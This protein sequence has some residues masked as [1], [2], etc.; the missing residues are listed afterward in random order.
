MVYV[1]DRLHKACCERDT[2]PVRLSPFK[3]SEMINDTGP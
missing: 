1:Y 2:N 3:K